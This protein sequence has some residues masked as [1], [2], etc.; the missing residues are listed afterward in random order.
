MPDSTASYHASGTTPNGGLSWRDSSPPVPLV[1]NTAANNSGY[2]YATLTID[3]SSDLPTL[4]LRL[5][6]TADK[7]YQI[8]TRNSVTDAPLSVEFP[9]Q[10]LAGRTIEFDENWNIQAGS[11]DDGVNGTL[12]W[13][14]IKAVNPPDSEAD[15]SAS[16]RR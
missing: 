7:A 9:R 3:P 13:G 10:S 1:Y 15:R 14:T 8:V 11:W 16:I 4:I 6:A 12:T 2:A 5:R